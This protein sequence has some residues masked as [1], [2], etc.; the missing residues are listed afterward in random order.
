M[1]YALHTGIWDR[2]LEHFAWI[3]ARIEI[4]FKAPIYLGNHVDVYTR[5][6][7]LGHKSTTLEHLLTVTSEKD[8]VIQSVAEAKSVMVTYNYQK[9]VSVPMP[10]SWRQQILHHEPTLR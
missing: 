3:V 10:E 1:A 9:Q 5:I 7:Y 8:N 4:D 6:T 2:T